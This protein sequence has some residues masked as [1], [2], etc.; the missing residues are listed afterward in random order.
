MIGDAKPSFSVEFEARVEE[1]EK[2]RMRNVHA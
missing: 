2:E 1:T